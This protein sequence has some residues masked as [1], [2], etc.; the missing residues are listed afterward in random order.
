MG[1]LMRKLMT[2]SLAVIVSCGSGVLLAQK[3]SPSPDSS[4]P[5]TQDVPRQEPGT[6]SPDLGKQ[7]APTPKQTPGQNN[8]ANKSPTENNPDVPHQEPGTDNPDLGKQRQPSPGTSTATSS[9]S[10]KKHKKNKSTA[11]QTQTTTH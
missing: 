3:Q 10:Q 1:E 4:T 9:K 5:N 7:R 8:P 11:S 6:D 2:I